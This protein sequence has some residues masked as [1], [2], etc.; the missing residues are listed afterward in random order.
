[1]GKIR[2]VVGDDGSGKTLYCVMQACRSAIAGRDVYIDFEILPAFKHDY[3]EA[4]PHIHVVEDFYSFLMERERE[5]QAKPPVEYKDLFVID[6]A[7]QI[8][9]ARRT[10]STIQNIA[11]EY[12]RIARHLGL[13]VLAN[14]Q[15]A[16]TLDVQFQRLAAMWVIA[17]KITKDPDNPNSPVVRFEFEYQTPQRRTIKTTKLRVEAAEKFYPYYHSTGLTTQGTMTPL[18]FETQR[19]SVVSREEMGAFK[20]KVDK[21]L[22]T[23]EKDVKGLLKREVS[24]HIPTRKET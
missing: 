22:R 9:N 8:W 10:S 20:K 1:M 24:A 13:E 16:R 15:L 5:A 4:W 19:A 11:V 12:L 21:R 23:L 3:P 14:T 2:C 6:E 7:A 17:H 18:G